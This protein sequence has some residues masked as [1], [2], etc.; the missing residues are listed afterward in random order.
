L[1]GD[2]VRSNE[3]E[4]GLGASVVVDGGESGVESEALLPLGVVDGGEGVGGAFGDI[5]AGQVAVADALA[6]RTLLRL[7]ADVAC[8]ELDLGERAAVDEDRDARAGDVLQL[9]PRM[10]P[11]RDE[12][13]E[14]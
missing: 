10:S 7:F 2:L 1:E 8:V 13:D 3:V 6:A 12:P 11:G 14:K 5:F 4:V 9:K